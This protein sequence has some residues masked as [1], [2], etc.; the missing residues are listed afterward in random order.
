[1][2]T[3]KA[4]KKMDRDDEL[5]AIDKFMAEKAE[6]EAQAA[7]SSVKKAKAKEVKLDDVAKAEPKKE[8]KAKVEKDPTIPPVLRY[9]KDNCLGCR[10]KEEPEKPVSSK[11]AATYT[12]LTLSEPIWKCCN[13]GREVAR[14]ERRDK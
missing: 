8:R 3:V 2:T 1:M 6:K 10:S 14:K 4:A 5:S 7:A 11:W 13:C 12:D 9:A